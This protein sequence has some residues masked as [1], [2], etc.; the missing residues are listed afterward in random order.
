MCGSPFLGLWHLGCQTN[1]IGF[2]ESI[3]SYSWCSRVE[4]NRRHWDFQSHALPTELQEHTYKTQGWKDFVGLEPTTVC[5]ADKCSTKWAKNIFIRKW[6]LWCVFIMVADGWIWTN[7]LLVMSQ[8]SY[9]TAPHRHI[10]DAGEGFEP[11]TTQLMRLVSYRC[12]TPQ[13]PR[14]VFRQC[15][16]L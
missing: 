13:Y 12:S 2:L 14:A 15:S 16:G 3:L 10:M 11:P 5:L 4:L 8:A 1:S 9:Q 7:D 6:L